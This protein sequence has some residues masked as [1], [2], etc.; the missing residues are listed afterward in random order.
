M[1]A[2]EPHA[3][4]RRHLERQIVFARP[5]FVVLALLDLTVI[6]PRSPAAPLN[7][8]AASAQDL[9]PVLFLCVYLAAALALLWIVGVQQMP[10]A[11]LPTWAEMALLAIFLVLTPSMAAFLYLMLF[12]AF[13]AGIR[14]GMER[15][16]LFCGIATLALLVSTALRGPF[17]WVQVIS[18]VALAGGTFAAGTGLGLLG[19]RNRR[20]A[21]EHEYLTH[22]SGLLEVEAGVAES[23]R[24]LLLAL[25]DA[26]DCG[27]ALVALYDRE[28]DRVFVWRAHRDEKPIAPENLPGVK[29]D[30]FLLDAQGTSVG[31]RSLE[32]SGEGFGWNRADGR[33][34]N[35][36]PRPPGPAREALG[37]RSLLAAP[38]EM[39]TRADA[40]IMVFN[41]ER[42]FSP[43]DLRWLERIARHLQ[44]PLK[45]LFLLRQMRGRAIE[46]E[47]NRISHDL[48]DGVL[49]TLLSFDIQLDVLRRQL[50][51]SADM[52]AGELTRLQNTMRGEAGEVRR[53]VNDMRPLRVGSADLGDLM[54]GFGERFA[55]ESGLALDLLMEG[56]GAEV[57]DRVCRELFQIYREALHNI[58]KH[59]QASHVVVKLWHDEVRVSLVVD[60]NGRGFSFAGRF[61]SDELDRLRL[62]PISI[63]ERTRSIG[64]V[65]TVESTPGHGARLIVEVPLN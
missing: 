60:D 54:R 31:W 22:L 35:P 27:G 44:S 25:T 15:V 38:L 59:S 2:M 58:K 52:L 7:L 13:V 41:A 36:L 9:A 18:W 26:F 55:Q 28:L 1:T 40:R 6:Q 49:Q 17:Q 21:G 24:R 39:D 53:I 34:I 12:V 61:T 19:A 20:H 11:D 4:E 50:P 37:L 57:P 51:R 30:A 48:H 65:L 56:I 64:G 32:G 29:R 10:V 16:V 45:N 3:A 47:R 14:W 23:L 62:G 33:P 63:K 43:D 46:G 42:R 8:V 5:I